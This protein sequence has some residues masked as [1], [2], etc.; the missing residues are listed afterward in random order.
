[1][2]TI[3][4]A[5]V[6]FA[7]AMAVTSGAWAATISTP[8]APAAPAFRTV[9]DMMMVV[10][11]SY[12]HLREKPNTSSKIL[13]TLNKGTKLDVVEKVEGGKWVH[14][15]VNNMEGYVSANLVK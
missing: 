4:I 10:S 1:M 11:H 13:G 9:A 15:K 12:A 6:G 5:A 8:A 7:A 3:Y 2:R 14:V